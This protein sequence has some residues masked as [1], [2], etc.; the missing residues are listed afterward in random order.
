MMK[1][2]IVVGMLGSQ[3][4]DPRFDYQGVDM[5]EWSP[6]TLASIT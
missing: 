6:H 3:Q 1:C 5:D 2:S 4:R